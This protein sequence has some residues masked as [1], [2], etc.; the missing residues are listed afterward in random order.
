LINRIE[1]IENLKLEN[2]HLTAELDDSKHKLW[3]LEN[4]NRNKGGL[5]EHYQS[6]QGKQ[7]NER[8][9]F[10]NASEEVR[11]RLERENRNLKASNNTL[12]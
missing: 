7:N 12:R 2:G 3:S 5:I 11:E 9:L 10:A 6:L 4:D 1:V 8:N